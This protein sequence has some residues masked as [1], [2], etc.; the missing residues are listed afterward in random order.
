MG[1]TTEENFL[2]KLRDRIQQRLIQIEQGD[3][4][5]GD[6]IVVDLT[7]ILAIVKE[8]DD[9]LNGPVKYEDGL[10][11]PEQALVLLTQAMEHARQEY[12]ELLAEA[13]KETT[14]WN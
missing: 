3:D 14:T 13:K 4:I 5:G 9:Y 10:A 7:L 12:I 11:V 1:S 6:R 2:P 8:F